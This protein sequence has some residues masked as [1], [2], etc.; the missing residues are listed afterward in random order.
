MAF[1]RFFDLALNGVE[2]TCFVLSS[3]CSFYLT[4][5]EHFAMLSNQINFENLDISLFYNERFSGAEDERDPDKN[6]FNE[7]NTQN[8]ECSY[9]LPNEIES[10]LSEK[11]NSEILRQS[12]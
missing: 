2:Q 6:F 7:V 3:T 1:T 10:F 12:M 8:L 4:C 5:N 9:F 11:E